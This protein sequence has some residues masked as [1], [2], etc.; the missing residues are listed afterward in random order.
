[1]KSGDLVRTADIKRAFSKGDSTNWMNELYTIIEVINDTIPSYRI[2]FVP[3]KYNENLV[4]PKK[5]TLDENNQVVEKLN[6]SIKTD[7]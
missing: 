1:M 7:N 2:N 3:K 4:R 5:V 6:I